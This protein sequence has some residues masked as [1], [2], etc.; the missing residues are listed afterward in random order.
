MTYANLDIKYRNTRKKYLK[1]SY[2]YNS[3]DPS[4]SSY[5]LISLLHNNSTSWVKQNS[6]PIPLVGYSK[7]VFHFHEPQTNCYGL[8]CN[9]RSYLCPENIIEFCTL[10]RV[11]IFWSIATTQHRPSNFNLK[12]RNHEK[13]PLFL[14]LSL[15]LWN[16][17]EF[18]TATDTLLYLVVVCASQAM[19]CANTATTCS[20]PSPR[21]FRKLAKQSSKN[22]CRIR[23]SS[24]ESD[25]N[26]EECAP[27]KEVVPWIYPI[28]FF[29][30]FSF[31]CA[32]FGYLRNWKW[33]DNKK[34]KTKY[35]AWHLL[36][37]YVVVY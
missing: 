32:T 1:Y 12:T 8:S 3:G 26:V 25:C 28:S 30:L 20:I 4:L 21:F 11:S 7:I 17:K 10:T 36:G 31:R 13:D 22:S 2:K 6:F 15:T 24:E 9:T 19:I 5:D 16:L 29:L 14:S 23:V 34:K 33:K 35:R 18:I 37:S 27:D